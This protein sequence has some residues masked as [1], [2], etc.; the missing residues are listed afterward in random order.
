MKLLVSNRL[1]AKAKVH[2]IIISAKVTLCPTRYV[3]E[4]RWVFKAPS[5]L[6]DPAIAA[7]STFG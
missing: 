4:A 5:A 7:S 2:V 6:F 1:I 3:L